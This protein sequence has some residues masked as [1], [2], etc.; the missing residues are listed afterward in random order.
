MVEERTANDFFGRLA[1]GVDPND[2]DSI[3][4]GLEFAKLK[5]VIDSQLSDVKVYRFGEI[6]I[7]TFI[8]GR[9]KTGE[10]AGL[11]TGVVET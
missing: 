9:T 3:A 7:S 5:T 2:P 1:N 8:V 11:L 6:A 10:L 4:R